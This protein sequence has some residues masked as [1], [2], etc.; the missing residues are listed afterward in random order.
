M[1]KE[2]LSKHSESEL[3]TIAFN[4]AAIGMAI[5][6]I[7]GQWLKVNQSF[8]NLTEYTEDELTRLTFQDITHPDDLQEDLSQVK[9]LLNKEIN[10]YQ[11]EKRYITKN[12]KTVNI[13]LSVSLVYD[14]TGAP[15]FFISQIQDITKLKSY[16]SELLKLIS[17]DHLT[18]IGNRRHF[19]EQAE[20]EIKRSGRT[21]SPVSILMIDIDHFKRINDIHGH[22][23][24]D[25]VLKT[26]ASTI[27][28]SIRSIDI[29]GRVGGEEFAALFPETN[30]MQAY[31]LAERLRNRIAIST[32][33]ISQTEPTTVS[34]GVVTFCGDSEALD[35]RIQQ[36]DK[37]LYKAKGLGRNRTETFIDSHS[38]ALK[39]RFASHSDFVNL[40]WDK[41][42][43][44]GNY[45]ID[46][47]HLSLLAV[48]NELLSCMIEG[49]DTGQCLVLLERLVD[50]VK[51]HFES[52]EA[53]LRA[54]RFI[55][56]ERHTKI[57]TQLITKLLALKNSLAHNPHAL[58]DIF[59]F[60]SVDVI[61][62][63]LILEDTKFFALFNKSK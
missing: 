31:I 32:Q 47:Q 36:A 63:H 8:C 59:S 13:I 24:G 14:D 29:L 15:S 26:I 62:N 11:L 61:R 55:D 1:N 54:S 46:A 7:S 39:P 41:S 57:H 50:H 49:A 12:G 40:T 10:S 19:Y 4:H 20:R 52:E 60:I 9:K 23:V 56:I 53:I 37:A 35:Q 17:E 25:D 43:E 30:D 33:Q 51:T 2:F 5:V 45:E 16:E 58:G 38:F 3:F 42:L 34:I 18:G 48:S 28:S 6:D 44:S 22:K 27:K 21:N